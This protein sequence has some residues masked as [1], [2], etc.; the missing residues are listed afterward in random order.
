MFLKVFLELLKQQLKKCQIFINVSCWFSDHHANRHTIDVVVDLSSVM[1]QSELIATH[2]LPCF[3]ISQLVPETVTA[4]TQESTVGLNRFGN[5]WDT[6]TDYR[7]KTTKK[8]TWQSAR[9]LPRCPPA[10]PG[11]WCHWHLQVLDTLHPE[12]GWRVKP[13]TISTCRTVTCDRLF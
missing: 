9:V 13:V 11:T 2:H 12:R 5:D 4:Q 7:K 3:S 10:S 1:L 8:L 6:I